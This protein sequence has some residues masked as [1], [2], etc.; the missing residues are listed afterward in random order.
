MNW[1][2]QYQ[3]NAWTGLEPVIKSYEDSEFAIQKLVLIAREMDMR[4]Q[5]TPS[6]F[7]LAMH[8][9]VGLALDDVEAREVIE[10]DYEIDECGV[11]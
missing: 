10:E 9:Y 1:K 3:S 5:I 11:F 2:Q 4:F 8:E 7:Q 6:V